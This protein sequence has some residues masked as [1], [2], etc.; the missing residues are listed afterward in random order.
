MPGAKILKTTAIVL[1]LMFSSGLNVP[2]S[3]FA[4]SYFPVPLFHRQEK[5]ETSMRPGET[6]YLFHSGTQDVKKGI[7][8]NDVLMVHRI[9]RS[10]QAVEVGK[11]KVISYVGETYV[12]GEVIEGEVRADDIAKKGDVSFLVVF[13]GICDSEK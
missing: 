6:V 12:K 3:A 1:L 7:H 2:L 13:A 8:P 11:I 5:L 10:C 9:N 4:A